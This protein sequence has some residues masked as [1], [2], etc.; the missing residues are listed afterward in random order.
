MSRKHIPN[1]RHAEDI[2]CP[3]FVAESERDIL[4]ESHMMDAKVTIIRYRTGKDKAIQRAC[5]CEGAYEKCEH[6]VSWKHWRWEDE[7]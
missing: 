2:R 7:D 1:T 6:Y 3:L 5:F 4:C